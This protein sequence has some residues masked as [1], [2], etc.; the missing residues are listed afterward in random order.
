MSNSP[1]DKTTSSGKAERKVQFESSKIGRWAHRQENPFAAQNRKRQAKKQAS[2]QKREKATP[3]VVLFGSA[4]V[5]GIALWGLVMLIVTLNNKAA[6]DAPDILGSTMEDIFAYSDQLQNFYNQ[7]LG[8]PTEQLEDVSKMVEGTLKKPS[9]K[10]YSNEVRLAQGMFYFSHEL[11][12]ETIEALSDID[13]ETLND[14]A[15]KVMYY[16]TMYYV[17]AVTGNEE[18]ANEYAMKGYEY[19][20]ELG[21]SG[22]GV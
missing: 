13:P 7:H 18:V 10:K 19:H 12:Y 21:G 11:Y 22:G 14:L 8:T 15:Q 9:G 16:D 1:Q 2:N 3:F 6:I 4:A 20:Q 17:Y 5:I